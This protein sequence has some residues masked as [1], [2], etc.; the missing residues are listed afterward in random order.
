MNETNEWSELVEWINELIS[1]FNLSFS[2]LALIE[3]KQMP[4]FEFAAITHLTQA[5]LNRLKEEREEL[6]V[7]NLE[8][9]IVPNS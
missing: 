9:G 4:M 5:N 1:G 2:L 7:S 8:L 6:V 3:F